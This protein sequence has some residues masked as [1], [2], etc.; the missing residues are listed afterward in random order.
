L[1][2]DI[3]ITYEYN[4]PRLRNGLTIRWRAN[5]PDSA[6]PAVSAVQ[7]GSWAVDNSP[8]AVVLR[9]SGFTPGSMVLWNGT[10]RPT[11]YLAENEIYVLASASD[12]SAPAT[13]NLV[14]FNALP[15]GGSSSAAAF[16]VHAPDFTMR[17]SAQNVSVKSAD[18]SVMTLT[19]EPAPVF[20]SEITF[21]CS[22]LPAGMSCKFAPSAIVPGT[23]PVVVTLNVASASQGSAQRARATSPVIPLWTQV[24]LGMLAMVGI[25]GRGSRR[26]MA[27]ALGLCVALALVSCGGATGPAPAS[28]SVAPAAS[29][30]TVPV[31]I[32]ASGGGL[33]RTQTVS[34]TYTK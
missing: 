33:A 27:G 21:T 7:P 1:D 23:M 9:G 31:V 17:A 34:V 12:L 20:R 3:G 10:P 29:T 19:V 8:V 26:R 22:G 2:G 25:V 16:I 6:S 13:H 18:S 32:T 24:G 14:V 15:G 11:T 28:V 4:E 30:A 5:L